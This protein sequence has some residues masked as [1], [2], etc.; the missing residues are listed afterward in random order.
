MKLA[1]SRERMKK[2]PTLHCPDKED[3]K[4]Y[5]KEISSKNFT[6]YDLTR[7]APHLPTNKLGNFHD[8]FR[9]GIMQ[10]LGL[11][12]QKIQVEYKEKAKVKEREINGNDKGFIISALNSYWHQA[13]TELDKRDLGDIER[14]N[15]EYQQ[16]KSKELMDKL[17]NL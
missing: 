11:A 7:I 12:K 10:R 15:Y 3:F 9:V 17:E 6:Y 16:K 5:F 1:T 8:D 4:K 13:R 2:I 14:R